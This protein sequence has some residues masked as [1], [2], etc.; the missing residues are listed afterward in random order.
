MAWFGLYR[1][2]DLLLRSP[3]FRLLAIGLFMYVGTE[4]AVAKWVVTFMERDEK[5]LL[6]RPRQADQPSPLRADD[7]KTAA[8]G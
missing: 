1:D 3:S 4:V 7:Q 6:H 2:R 5:I 8:K